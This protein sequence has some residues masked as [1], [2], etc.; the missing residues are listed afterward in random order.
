MDFQKDH[1]YVCKVERISRV[2]SIDQITLKVTR[3]FRITIWTTLRFR[4]VKTRATWSVDV[5]LL[6]VRECAQS[7][8]GQSVEKVNETLHH[9]E[10]HRQTTNHESIIIREI[11]SYIK[12][13][14]D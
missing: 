2:R 10:S 12:K 4:R 13:V 11:C 14:I 9:V 6:I 1:L 7:G 3:R 8:R 5:V